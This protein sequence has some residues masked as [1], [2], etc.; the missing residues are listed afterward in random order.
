LADIRLSGKSQ[1]LLQV[2]HLLGTYYEGDV[3]P[4]HSGIPLLRFGSPANRNPDD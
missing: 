3:R 2:I 1:S 4:P